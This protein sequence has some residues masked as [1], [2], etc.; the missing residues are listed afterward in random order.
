M[1][2]VD[3]A[4]ERC[5]LAADISSIIARKAFHSLKAPIVTVTA[6]HTPAPFSPPLEDLYVPSET[7]IERAVREVLA[8]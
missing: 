6:P 4:P 8:A 1:V 2:V 5:S 7:D 3:E